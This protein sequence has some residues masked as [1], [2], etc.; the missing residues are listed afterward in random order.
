M[1]LYP[2][3]WYYIGYYGIMSYTIVLNTILSYAM[4]LYSTPWYYALFH[5]NTPNYANG[6]K[7]LY[8]CAYFELW[9][10]A[11]G[12]DLQATAPAAAPAAGPFATPAA[13]DICRRDRCSYASVRVLRR[14]QPRPS[15]AGTYN[16]SMSTLTLA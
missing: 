9:T 10:L 4:A 12:S 11:R 16:L 15:S 3:P 13:G 2:I 7:Q 14:E 6:A 5:G 1:A 8:A